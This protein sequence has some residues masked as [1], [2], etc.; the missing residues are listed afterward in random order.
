MGLD[1]SWLWGVLAIWAVLTC[2]DHAGYGTKELE[3]AY[4]ENPMP[5]ND[6]AEG[7]EEGGLLLTLGL[8][9]VG[10]VWGVS[11]WGA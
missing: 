3:L 8:A 1:I 4:T 9:L 6:P 10:L 11:A 7:G 2:G 5:R